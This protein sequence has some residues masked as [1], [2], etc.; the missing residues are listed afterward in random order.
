MIFYQ[1]FTNS[2]IFFIKYS[3]YHNAFIN[4][5]N[6]QEKPEDSLLLYCYGIFIIS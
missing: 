4:T 3:G 1:Q 2:I 5:K 6:P